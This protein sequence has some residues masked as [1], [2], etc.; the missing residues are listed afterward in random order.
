MK[1][2]FSGKIV[3]DA[4][5]KTRIVRVEVK[6]KHPLLGKI[7]KKHTRIMCHDEKNETKVGDTVIIEQTRP[8]SKKKHFRIIEVKK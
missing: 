7:A 5:D 1:K 2:K 3:S 8:L 4:M 6:R